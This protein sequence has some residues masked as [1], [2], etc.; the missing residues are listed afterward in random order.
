MQVF[1][2]RL[3]TLIIL[4]LVIL[5]FGAVPIYTLFELATT[6]EL[7]LFEPKGHRRLPPWV[8]YLIAWL[9]WLWFLQVYARMLRYYRDP[10]M[11]TLGPDWIQVEET[12]IPFE[13]VR[14]IKGRLFYGDTMIDTE[15][16]NFTIHVQLA[17]RA[18]SALLAAFP[19]KYETNGYRDG[20][21]W[22]VGK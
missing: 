4:F 18:V 8:V 17:S 10:R 20:P 12:Q 21:S 22:F 9:G 14:N 19:E 5:A 2:V 16:G 13:M 1:R 15:V 3:R 7:E 6:G 11:F